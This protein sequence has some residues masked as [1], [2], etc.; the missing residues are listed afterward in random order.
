MKFGTAG[1]VIIHTHETAVVEG[2]FGSLGT[3]LRLIREV[4]VL[5]VMLT[6]VV[7][8]FTNWVVVASGGRD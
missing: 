1:E 6:A 3:T 8:F 5:V 7:V 4:L 2:S